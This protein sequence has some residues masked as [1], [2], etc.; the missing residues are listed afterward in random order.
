MDEKDGKRVAVFSLVSIGDEE[1]MLVSRDT[2][3]RICRN[4]TS[5]VIERERFGK[6]ETK[7]VSVIK[8]GDTE[9]YS[10]IGT[11]G[12]MSLFHCLYLAFNYSENFF[13]KVFFFRQD[14]ASPDFKFEMVFTFY[15]EQERVS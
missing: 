7:E 15:G 14:F 9:A 10:K 3:I 12:G 8:V 4:G 6:K 5:L 2:Y 11:A 13:E 1:A